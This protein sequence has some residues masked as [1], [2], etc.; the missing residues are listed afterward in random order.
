VY[1]TLVSTGPDSVRIS[2]SILD[3]RKGVPIGEV[4]VKGDES[5]MDALSDSLTVGLLRELGAVRPI[6]ATRSARFGS[7]TVPALKAFLTGEQLYRRGAWD[8]AYAAFTRAMALDSTFVQPLVRAGNATGW[9]SGTGSEVYT[10]LIYRAA[11]LNRGLGP[12]DSLS[13]VIDSNQAAL[14][15]ATLPPPLRRQ[16][17]KRLFETVA[18]LTRH[19]PHDPEAWYR[20]G[21]TRFHHGWMGR[22]RPREAMD[23]FD[24]AIALDSAFTPAYPHTMHLNGWVPRE[25][26]WDR[27]LGPYLASGAAPSVTA[28]VRLLQ[29]LHESDRARSDSAL[30]AASPRLLQTAAASGY[31]MPDSGEPGVQVTRELASRPAPTREDGLARHVSYAVNLGYRGHLREAARAISEARDYPDA[32]DLTTELALLGAIPAD[33]ADALLAERLRRAPYPQPGKYPTGGGPGTLGYSSPWWAARRDSASLLRFAARADSAARD[34]ALTI[35]GER[36]AY[37]ARAARAYL[38]LVRGDSASAL[39]QL[40]DLPH[41]V[42]WGVM[43][44]VIEARL[45]AL[46]GRDAEILEML[47]RSIPGFWASPSMVL[48]RLEMARAAERLGR[49]ARAV[50][51]YRFVVDVWRHADPELR[52]YVDEARAALARLSGEPVSQ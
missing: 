22:I 28:D 16:M 36:A 45:L 29:V 2:A 51:D 35:D 9:S 13:I 12:R 32:S 19:Y 34:S 40:A 44:R 41:D 14:F 25:D 47:D 7:T 11:A 50:E 10:S 18:E 17:A 52:S 33:T 21:E 48:A 26:G 5:H 38:T 49:R 8:S 31:M 46:R 27:H 24:R 39:R 15:G 4:Q 30:R 37:D 20:L 3:V 6:G 23:P 43:D 1:G 42:S